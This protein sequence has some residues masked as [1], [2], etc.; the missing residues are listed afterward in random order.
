[1]R[2]EAEE[3]EGAVALGYGLMV[4]AGALF[5][6]VDQPRRGINFYLQHELGKR[7]LQACHPHD[8]DP[9]NY[10]A[11]VLQMPRGLSY[12]LQPRGRFLFRDSA[13]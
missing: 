12:R 10:R 6:T 7:F 9:R 11:R 4:G 13:F 5:P 3:E 8:E 2:E 1:M